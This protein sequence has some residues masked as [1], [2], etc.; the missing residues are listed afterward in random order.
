MHLATQ[1]AHLLNFYVVLKLCM[2][3]NFFLQSSLISSVNVYLCTLS[4]DNSLQAFDDFK[5]FDFLSLPPFR[6]TSRSR[7]TRS[8]HSD[9]IPDNP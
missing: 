8:S 4:F 5:M 3:L 7:G 1:D 9:T 6:K 2:L